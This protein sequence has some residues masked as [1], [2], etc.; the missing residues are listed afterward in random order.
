M[1]DVARSSLGT[2]RVTHGA[3]KSSGK[4]TTDVRQALNTGR[5]RRNGRTKPLPILGFQWGR[6]E[7]NER[8]C[9]FRKARELIRRIRSE[10]IH[11]I[12]HDVKDD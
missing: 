2:R 11:R 5:S 12:A 1:S 9:V 10:E 4:T 7:M 6:P 3:G 8:L